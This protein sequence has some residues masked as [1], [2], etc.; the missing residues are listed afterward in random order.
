VGARNAV[1]IQLG[2]F[3]IGIN[4]TKVLCPA[5]NQLIGPLRPASYVPDREKNVPE[6]ALD[7]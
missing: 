4:D 3:H 6:A 1:K 7:W 2:N 5:A